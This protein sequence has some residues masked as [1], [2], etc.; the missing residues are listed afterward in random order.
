MDVLVDRAANVSQQHALQAMKMN[1]IL[2]GISRS[3]AG[4]LRV[5]AMLQYLTL[6]CLHLGW[7]IEFLGPSGQ[8]TGWQSVVSVAEGHWD[9][10]RLENRCAGR[11][12]RLSSKMHNS[13]GHEVQQ[14]K[15]QSETRR[16]LFT[17]L[18]SSN[19]G[20]PERF[21]NRHPWRYSGFYQVAQSFVLSKLEAGPALSRRLDLYAFRGPFQPDLFP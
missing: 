11:Q 8:E 9:Y 12:A 17:L 7:C 6:A 13:N 4:R 20:Y 21:R 10:C 14:G 16:G 19:L 2:C 15:S 1:H 18:S 3:I 5:M